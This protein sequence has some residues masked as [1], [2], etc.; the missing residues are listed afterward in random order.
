MNKIEK[1]KAKYQKRQNNKLRKWWNK[2]DYKVL[3][4]L[5]FY[6]WIPTWL[7][8]KHRAN[9]Y[10]KLVW[11]PETAKKYLDK[12]LPYLVRNETEHEEILFTNADDMG[13]IKFY[14]SFSR[15]EKVKRYKTA[16]RYLCKFN[17]QVKQFIIE[18]Y[19]IEGYQK[20]ILDNWT[21]WDKAA[22]KFDWYSGPWDK[23]YAVGVIFYKEEKN[24]G[25]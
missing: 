9:K 1:A 13:G 21:L 3:R 19:Q 24:N 20:M 17:Q 12:V 25:N 6:I 7:C 15:L 10:R 11:L 2:N 5:F 23:D 4:V 22:K 14:W 8:E 18:E 16:A